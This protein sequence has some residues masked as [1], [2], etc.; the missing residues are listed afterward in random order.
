M[1]IRISLHVTTKDLRYASRISRSAAALLEGDIVDRVVVTG[2]ARGRRAELERPQP[3]VLF[4]RM[5]SAVRGLP[6][7]LAT[8][9]IKEIDRTIRVIRLARRLRPIVVTAR[10]AWD[11]PAS[12][13]AAASVG[14]V[15]VY[16]PH[17]LESCRNGMSRLRARLVRLIEGVFARRAG[18]CVAVGERIADLYSK[19]LEIPCFTVL[20]VPPP[21]PP[22][23]V[24]GLRQRAGIRA[25]DRV[26]AYVGALVEGRGLL[27][28]AKAVRLAGTSWRMVAMGSGPMAARLSEALGDHGGVVAPV[29]SRE[30]VSAIADADLSA[31]LIEPIC[32]SYRL[33]MPNKLFESLRAGVPVIATDLP[34]LGEFVRRHGVGIVIAPGAGAGAIAEA[35]ASVTDDRLALW[36]AAIP[37]ALEAASSTVGSATLVRAYRAAMAR[38]RS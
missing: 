6:R 34:E 29:A 32:E 16:E 20:N 22:V 12:W 18:A 9:A 13:T 21:L 2:I 11:L 36:R 25:S 7:F 31:V 26:L 8:Q 33:C 5:P 15:L 35:L 10:S 37:R 30:V 38:H 14:A 19:R 3:R 27:D 17:E 4:L 24:S 1:S 23:M 28:I